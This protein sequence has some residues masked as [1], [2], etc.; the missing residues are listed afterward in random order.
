MASKAVRAIREMLRDTPKGASHT[1]IG[2]AV[3]WDASACCG[4]VPAEWRTHQWAQVSDTSAST[5]AGVAGD[6][7]PRTSMPLN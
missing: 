3:V 1:Y 2:G 6:F 7:R 4:S 5:V